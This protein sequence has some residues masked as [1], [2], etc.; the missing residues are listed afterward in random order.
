M[1]AAE[2]TDVEINI[3]YGKDLF[4]T[5][6]NRVDVWDEIVSYL[7]RNK[8]ERSEEILTIPDFDT[9]PEMRQIIQRLKRE[10]PK[11]TEDEYEA[12]IQLEEGAKMLI[13]NVDG[14]KVE[15]SYDPS[16]YYYTYDPADLPN[17]EE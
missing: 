1:A 7:Q 2:Q 4:S 10:E 3:F 9:S 15:T 17:E 14:T 6:F 16:V 8:Q 12:L 11:V 5:L 13:T